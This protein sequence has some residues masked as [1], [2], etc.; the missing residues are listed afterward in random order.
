M[1]SYVDKTLD[2]VHVKVAVALA[3]L[4]SYPDYDPAVSGPAIKKSMDKVLDDPMFQLL[5]KLSGANRDLKAE[6]DA[7]LQAAFGFAEKA[8]PRDGE[9]GYG[10]AID[11]PGAESA[12]RERDQHAAAAS[13]EYPFGAAGK[14]LTALIATIEKNE[15]QPL[16][17]EQKLEVVR[18]FNKAVDDGQPQTVIFGTNGYLVMRNTAENRDV[19][20]LLAGVLGLGLGSRS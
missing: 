9:G 10:E 20:A 13:I 8:A 2:V 14:E 16:T 3:A 1:T 11:F 7:L 4:L 18:A 6:A 12:G 17:S 5:A 15:G 19:A